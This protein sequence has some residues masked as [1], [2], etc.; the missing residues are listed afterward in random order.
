MTT[1]CAHCGSADTE[2]EMD[3]IFCFAC[4]GH[5]D[6]HGNALPR[7]PQ[8]VGPNWGGPEKP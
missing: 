3:R 6:F 4:G 2:A 5:T 8:F 7:D 1:I